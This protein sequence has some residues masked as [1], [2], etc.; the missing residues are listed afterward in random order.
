[1]EFKQ[2]ENPLVSDLSK[3]KFRIEN[4]K[5]IV[6]DSPG[7]GIEID[8]KCNR[9]VPMGTMKIFYGDMSWPEVKEASRELG[10]P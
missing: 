7:I 3:E 10:L 6:P 5:L 4:G 2:E 9:Q 1:M 8:R